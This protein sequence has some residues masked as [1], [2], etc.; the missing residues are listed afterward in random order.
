MAEETPRLI[1]LHYWGR[2]RAA[3]LATS[4]K[5]ALDTQGK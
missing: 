4:V 1:F 5:K 3:E 2:G